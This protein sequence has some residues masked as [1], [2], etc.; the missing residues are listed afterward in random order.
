MTAVSNV[1]SISLTMSLVSRFLAAQGSGLLES[2][3]Q[4]LSL[5]IGIVAAASRNV[6]LASSDIAAEHHDT[7]TWI[8]AAQSGDGEAY[9]LLVREFQDQ[10]AE[11]I[12]RFSR[13]PQFCEELTH[14]VFVEAF[15][16]MR[17]YRGSAPWMHWLRRIAVRIG[18]LYWQEQKRGRKTVRM[19]EEA[20]E[21]LQNASNSLQTAED[22]AEIVTKMLEQLSLNDRLVLTMIYLDG[23]TMAEAASRCGWTV[24][25]TKLRAFRARKKLAELIERGES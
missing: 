14:D 6:S 5:W 2:L 13:D 24:T 20:F 16:S 11:Q 7:T 15:L 22:A 9:R 1:P 17:S 18:Y 10:I 12:R 25:G 23:C 21:N 19:T 4:P 8:K 3:R